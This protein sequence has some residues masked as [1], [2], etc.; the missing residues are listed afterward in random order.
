MH[1]KIATVNNTNGKNKKMKNKKAK[2]TNF[3]R[4]RPKE[5]NERKKSQ[6]TPW[7]DIFDPMRSGELNLNK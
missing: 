5:T 2:N 6:R 1:P 4:K 3:E 7:K